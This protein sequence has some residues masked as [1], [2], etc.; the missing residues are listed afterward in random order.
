MKNETLFLLLM[1]GLAA[2]GIARSLRPLPS[3]PAISEYPSW[4][5]TQGQGEVEWP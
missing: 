5:L 2:T 1:L 3:M 4:S